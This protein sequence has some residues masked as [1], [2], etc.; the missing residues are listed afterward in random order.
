MATAQVNMRV[1]DDARETVLEIGARLRADPAFAD[2]LRRF[3]DGVGN[4]SLADRVATL[5]AR[6]D[7][8]EGGTP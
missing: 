8:L 6:L 4:P 7:A 3:L 1:P 2:Q 5:E